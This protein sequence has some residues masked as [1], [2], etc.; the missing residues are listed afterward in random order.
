MAMDSI[1]YQLYEGKI[2]Y[3]PHRD[4]LKN[5]RQNNLER[6]EDALNRLKEKDAV[7]YEE[8]IKLMGELTEEQLISAPEMF[9]EGF[10]IG[11]RMMIE[12]FMSA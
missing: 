8:V 3:G 1:L 5:R 9:C 6:Y 4:V 2:C 10:S 11:A 12:V 7:L